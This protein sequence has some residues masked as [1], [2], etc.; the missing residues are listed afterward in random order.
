M[1]RVEQL[2]KPPLQKRENAGVVSTRYMSL[3]GG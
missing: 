2:R 3:E 1:D